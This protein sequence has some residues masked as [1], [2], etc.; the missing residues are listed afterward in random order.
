VFEELGVSLG[1]AVALGAGVARGLQ[2]GCGGA[3]VSLTQRDDQ[4]AVRESPLLAQ[5]V[6]VV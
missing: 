5:S 2:L 3:A 6:P 4:P 1:H